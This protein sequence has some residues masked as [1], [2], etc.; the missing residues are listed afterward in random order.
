MLFHLY[1]LLL[2]Q[3]V[4]TCAVIS[5]YTTTW[6]NHKLLRGLPWPDPKL[7]FF[8][9]PF[10]QTTTTAAAGIL[11]QP[12]SVGCI[13]M[14][15]A[16]RVSLSVR[17]SGRGAGERERE[18]AQRENK[19]TRPAELWVKTAEANQVRFP[20]CYRGLI[21]KQKLWLRLAMTLTFA[22]FNQKFCKNKSNSVH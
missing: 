16:V 3:T 10:F 22:R 5:G 8:V 14:K 7:H 21:G 19:H 2:W 12:N 4:S 17:E 11:D 20:R 18:G 1:Y 15:G 13:K 6:Q 9:S